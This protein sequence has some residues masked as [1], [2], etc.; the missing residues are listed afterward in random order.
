ME[1]CRK[2]IFGFLHNDG[3]EDLLENR[4][5]DYNEDRCV[6]GNSIIINKRRRMIIT[7]KRY[8]YADLIV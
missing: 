3:L 4:Q 8:E 5:E 2:E 6:D 7:L 1:S